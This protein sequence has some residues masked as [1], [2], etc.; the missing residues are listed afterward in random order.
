MSDLLQ[1]Q[2]ALERLFHEEGQ[3]IV[4]WNDPLQEFLIT[5]STLLLKEVKILRLDQESALKVKIL[6]EEQEPEQKFLLYAAADEPLYDSDWLLDIRLYSRSFRADRASILLQELGL[7]QQSLRSHLS[8]RGKFFDSKDRLA[9]LKALLLPDDVALDLDRKMIAV[10]T[11]ADQAELFDLVRTLFHGWLEGPVLDLD[12]EPTVWEQLEKFD[13]DKPFWEMVKTSFGYENDTPNLKQFLLRLLVTDFNHHLKADCPQGLRSLLLPERGGAN[14]VVC[15][16]Q[17]RD[18]SS[19]GISYDKLANEVAALLKLDIHLQNFEIE[20]LV[21]VPTFLPVEK[22]LASLIRNRIQQ[23]AAA[24]QLE[25]IRRVIQQRQI[26][27]WANPNLI[28]TPDA[29]REA[30]HAV[31]EALLS[32]AEFFSLKNQFQNGFDFP[33]ALAVYRAYEGELYKFDQLYRHF[34]EA[35]DRAENQGWDIAKPL[36]E[37]IEAH[38]NNWYL[39]SLSLAWGRFFEGDEGL[40]GH[41]RL[42]QVPNQY[43]FYERNIAPWVGDSESRRA[44]VI[45]S[46][47]FRYEAA[48]ELGTH[49]NSKYRMEATLT[50]QLGVL[51]S[52]TALGMASLLPHRWLEYQGENV[53]VDGHASGAGERNQILEKVGGMACKAEEIMSKKKEDGREFVRDKRIVYIYHDTVDAIGDDAKTE[54]NTFEAVRKAIGDLGSL[55]SHLVN[56]L[57][58]NHIVVTADHGFLYSQSHPAETDKSKLDTK[59]ASAFLA[60]KRYILGQNL[61]NLEKAWFGQV[62]TTASVR[63][64]TCFLIPKGTNRFHFIGGAR[65]VHGGA[66]P[67]EVVVP[68]LTIKPIRGR[69]TKS[70]SVSVHVLGNQHRITT[71]ICRFQLFQM[72]P[73]SDRVKAITLKVGIYEGLSSV[74]DTKTVKF[75]CPTDNM[76]ERKKWVTLTLTGKSFHKKTVY[77]LVLVDQESG[78]EQASV[79]VIIDRAVADDF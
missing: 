61:A 20:P 48:Q 2:T 4:F 77:R 52:Y 78:I 59:P 25:P 40:L 44:F 38:Y 39:S 69:N 60:K 53:M 68:V 66:M 63:D 71:G 34:S 73:T 12:S 24:I 30:L 35:A 26:G 1:I 51:P 57:N 14:A 56:N 62:K 58:A 43:R 36:R 72:E 37:E 45:I 79:E 18:S 75:D 74:S 3:R 19:R 22:H 65:F 11:K 15:L 46:D 6:L 21:D 49:L 50:S 27:H 55:V 64:E 13:L 47:A 31:Y 33:D 67:Q 41:W 5:V 54:G 76:D 16:A 9:K 70:K 8:T 32:A 42:D 7:N 29:P 10:V 28:F 17:W 23:T